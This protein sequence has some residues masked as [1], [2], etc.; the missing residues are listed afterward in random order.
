VRPP[1][2]ILEELLVSL[3]V[4]EKAKRL[5]V[6]NT[7]ARVARMYQDELL[8]GYRPGALVELAKAF[9]TFPAGTSNEMVTQGPIP[10]VSLCAHH[11]LPFVGEMWVGYIPSKTLVGLSKLSRVLRHFSSQLQMQEHLTTQ[12]ADQLNDWLKPKAL[13]VLVE[14]RHYC[15]EARGVKVAGAVTKTSA[16]RGSAM[17]EPEVRAEFYRLISMGR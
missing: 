17:S 14:A 1:E 10:F 11:M 16:L 9:K 4:W 7:P 3:G 5:D 2:L 8:A 12:V 15:M 6:E 13:I